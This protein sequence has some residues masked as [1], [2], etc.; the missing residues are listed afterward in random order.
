LAVWRTKPP[1]TSPV[2]EKI[3][4]ERL[5]ECAEMNESA[6]KMIVRSKKLT[7]EAQDLIDYIHKQRL[8]TS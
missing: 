2:F 3:N 5:K 7:E 6:K 4:L 8:K 1:R